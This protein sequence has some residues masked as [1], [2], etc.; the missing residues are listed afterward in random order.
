M[1]GFRRAFLLVI[2][3][4]CLMFSSAP[5]WA[6]SNEPVHVYILMDA[7]SMFPEETRFAGP[8]TDFAEGIKRQNPKNRVSVVVKNDVM[9]EDSY[10]YFFG[11][12]GGFTHRV[13]LVF[14]NGEHTFKDSIAKV[15]ELQ[16][17]D[18][19]SYRKVLLIMDGSCDIFGK[20]DRAF[21]FVKSDS[22]YG[23]YENL[24]TQGFMDT[25]KVAEPFCKN[26]EVYSIRFPIYS[27]DA[28]PKKYAAYTIKTFDL[29]R[30]MGTLILHSLQNQGYYEMKESDPREFTNVLRRYEKKII[31]NKRTRVPAPYTITERIISGGDNDRTYDISV[32]VEKTPEAAYLRNL[33]FKLSLPA[34]YEIVRDH[35][36]AGY[37]TENEVKLDNISGKYADIQRKIRYRGKTPKPGDK[38]TLTYTNDD[39]LPE[40]TVKSLDIRPM[41]LRENYWSFPN[42]GHLQDHRF[43]NNYVQSLYDS[44]PPKER[45]LIDKGMKNNAGG[46]CYGMAF[47]SILSNKDKLDK[48]RLGMKDFDNRPL[49]NS[50][51]IAKATKKS[52]ED[53]I[54]LYQ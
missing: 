10:G 19:P 9:S 48:E 6:E 54:H 51:T 47:T 8:I 37:S 12:Y 14:G 36:D 53:I 18:D 32:N 41:V 23:R 30:R 22:D 24:V 42:F 13:N 25:M 38:I 5:T 4:T 26:Q 52:A 40:R 45:K 11:N 35:K 3:A 20:A 39:Y 43:S 29:K 31:E 49:K 44:L 16:K 28:G 17:K 46:N 33:R 34:G 7:R 27:G 15:K 50:D 2:L 1:K 21:D